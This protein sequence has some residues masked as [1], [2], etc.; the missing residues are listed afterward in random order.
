MKVDRVT[1]KLKGNPMTFDEYLNSEKYDLD[2][3]ETL[4][5]FGWDD[6]FSCSYNDIGGEEMLY[7]HSDVKIYGTFAS[8]YRGNDSILKKIYWFSG[9]EEAYKM[10]LKNTT[11]CI[12]EAIINTDSLLDL[13]NASG[14][15]YVNNH[16]K[17]LRKQKVID[18]SNTI[19]D[20]LKYIVVQ[21][22]FKFKAIRTLKEYNEKAS[23][24]LIIP[25]RL[26]VLRIID[27]SIIKNIA[28]K[29]NL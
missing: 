15:N 7:G 6:F 24:A 21:P 9:Y 11:D 16:Y 25:R 8:A 17:R 22:D 5:D 19:E 12:A 23:N 18:K 4:D 26:E 1:D 13:L 14:V 3:Q 29:T 10:A 2:M 28:Y 27:T 20:V